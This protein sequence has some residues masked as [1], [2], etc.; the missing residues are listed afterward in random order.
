MLACPIQDRHSP[1]LGHGVY[2]QG[3]EKVLVLHDW[4]GDSANYLPLVPYLDFESY[5][6]AFADVRGYGKSLQLTGAYTADEIARDAFALA[7]S[8]EWT[9]FH[10]VGH[11]MTGM[12][13]Q[14]MALEDAT[15]GSKRLKSIV[16]ITPVA[17][18]GYPADEATKRFL[19]ELIHERGLSEQGFSLL[20]GQRLTPAWGRA[21]TER[22]LRTSSAAAL[23]AYYR[24]WLETDFSQDVRDARVATPM[25]V[26]GGRQDLPGF[27][28]DHLRKTFGAWYPNVEFAFIAESG[29]YPM[30]ETPVYLAS[31][32]E[33]FL[34]AN[35]GDS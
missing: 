7:D 1:V 15:S 35:G 12:A 20:T 22:H 24:M 4:M 29:H 28:E 32:I 34:G 13:V 5:T 8:L 17:A 2:G 26:I 6:Y 19:W 11:S 14:R 33:R 31:L 23:R 9:R 25:L 30:Q 21:K 16:A 18:N 3:R 10:A 27:Q